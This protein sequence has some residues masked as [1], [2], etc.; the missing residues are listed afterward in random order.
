MK[1]FWPLCLIAAGLLVVLLGFIYDLAYAGIP[2]QDPTPE[3]AARFHQ[4][5]RIAS[6]IRWSG[7]GIFLAGVVA[8]SLR[9]IGR[10]LRS[11]D[12]SRG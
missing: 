4:N 6:L 7:F 11:T 10:R 8:G 5:A 1:R 3:M 2:Y 9:R 12:V